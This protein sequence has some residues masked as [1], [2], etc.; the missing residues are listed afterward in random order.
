MALRDQPYMPLYVQDFLTDEK[1]NECSAESTG[2]YIRL[3]CIMHK[4]QEYG[5]I[6]LKQRDKQTGKQTSDFALKL[7]KQMPYDSDTI[8]RALTELL[9]ESVLS[10]DGD[11]LFQKRMVKDGKISDIRAL[12]GSKGGKQKSAKR[13]SDSEFANDF[14][15][16]KH[17]ANSEN[18][19]EIENEYENIKESEGDVGKETTS[20]AQKESRHKYSTYGWVLLTDQEYERLLLELGDAELKR[21]IEYIDESAQA[22]GNK[23]KWKDWNL[24]IRR[25]SKG[26]WGMNSYSSGGKPVER[27]SAM[28]DLRDLHEI[29]G[30]E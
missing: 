30:E 11:I 5:T 26:R 23:N 2:V 22:T 3:M 9:E 18:E 7:V 27:R 10:L 20:R 1:L 29:Y 25:C 17:V 15:T 13:D 28:D 12:A 21:C 24:V 8:E 19:N 6:L 14:A 16:A 4:S